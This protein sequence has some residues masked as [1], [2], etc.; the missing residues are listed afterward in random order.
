MNETIQLGHGGGGRLSHTLI[1]EEI[2][3]RFG[4]GPLCGLPDAASLTVAGGKIHFSTDGFVVQPLIFP[5]G[6][7][8]SLAVHGT[9]ND[10]AVSGARPR[11]LSLGL[12]LEE[13]LSMTLLRQV[14]DGVKRAAADCGVTVVTGDTKVVR[15]GQCDGIYITT[16]G[17][18]EALPGFQ[19]SMSSIRPG[20]RILVSGSLGDH[21]A[22]VMAVREG[23]QLENGPKSD[24]RPVHRLVMALEPVAGHVRFMRDPTRGGLAAVLNEVVVDQPFGMHI[25]ENDLPISPTTGILAEILGLDL[26]HVASEGCL[27]LFCDPASASEVLGIWQRMPEGSR[28]CDIGQVTTERGRVVLETAIGG[29]RVVDLPQGELLP[30]IC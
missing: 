13:G 28:A 9:I 7:I 16:A 8:G 6:D 29:Q 23:F 5:G 21:G 1:Q 11:W 26:L 24:S 22:A 30:R 15:R 18:G 14:L 12:I 25:R 19:L 17:L 10:L 4:A 2:V 20:D 27:V 3:S